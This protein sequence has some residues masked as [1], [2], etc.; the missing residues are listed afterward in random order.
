[1][2]ERFL[3]A[4][5]NGV[6]ETALSEISKDGYKSSHWMWYI[7][8]QLKGLGFSR[9]AEKYSIENFIEANEYVNNTI[10]YQRL[11]NISQA[12]FDIND[13]TIDYIFDYPDNLK[14][15]SCMTLFALI[16][17][18]EP[19]FQ[20]NLDKYFNGEMCEYTQNKFYGL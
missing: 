6:Y 19:I 11:L 10:L 16:C 5:A 4:Q 3:E 7:F 13:K 18:D 8:P 20:L 2:I 15:Q 14:F 17:P 9:M 1:M 12:V